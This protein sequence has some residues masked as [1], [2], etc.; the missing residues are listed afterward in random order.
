MKFV[1]SVL[2]RI[3]FTIVLIIAG[4]A[5]FISFFLFVKDFEP[6][7]SRE[8]GM[9]T[10]INIGIETVSKKRYMSLLITPPD[11]TQLILLRDTEK[12]EVSIGDY[13]EVEKGKIKLLLPKK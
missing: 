10:I 7:N 9:G 6:R 2:S 4:I 8:Y 3:C 5:F 1:K 12:M 13:V 11:N